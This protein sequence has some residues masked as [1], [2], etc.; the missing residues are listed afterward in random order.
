MQAEDGDGGGFGDAAA[1]GDGKAGSGE[2]G[3]EVGRVPGIL[4][5]ADWVAF[6]QA[7]QG[8]NVLFGEQLFFHGGIPAACVLRSAEDVAIV[9]K[10]GAG[11]EVQRADGAFDQQAS[12]FGN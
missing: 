3:G 7:P 10:N 9:A 5:D 2:G 8:D 4:V 11:G 1:H 12:Y 6:F